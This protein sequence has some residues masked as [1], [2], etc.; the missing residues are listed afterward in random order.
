MFD[1][2]FAF[3]SADAERARWFDLL[4]VFDLETTGIDVRS[5]RIVAAH[6]GVID[7][8]GEALEGTSWL[9]DPGIEIPAGASAV[10]GITTEY[11]REHGRPAGEVVAEV[12]E[13]L[14]SLLERGIP[15]VVYN[16]PY[17]LSLLAHESRRWG[18]PVLLDPSPIV[19]PLVID[20]AVDRYRKGKRTLTVTA[21]HYG[22]ALTEA[23]DAA[24]DALAAGRIAQALGG[25]FADELG[26]GAE[27]LHALQVEW[28][29]SQAESFQ[30]Y[31]RRVRDESF[32]ADGAWPVRHGAGAP[33][34]EG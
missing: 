27:A 23:H 1:D 10:H 6:V 4:A 3:E 20:K 2:A 33:T 24:A 17:D 5:S 25:A 11:A 18:V 34:D 9:A 8:A 21:Q 22:V 15:V 19:D 14:R 16:A 13:A 29:R 26:V 28:C 31:M 7:A 12:S 32:V 30:D